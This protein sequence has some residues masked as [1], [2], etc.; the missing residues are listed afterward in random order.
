MDVMGILD[1]KEGRFGQT[2]KAMEHYSDPPRS[3]FCHLTQAARKFLLCGATQSGAPIASLAG[4]TTVPTVAV[5]G[6]P[7]NDPVFFVIEIHEEAVI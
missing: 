5:G 6:E 2:P 3:L 7:S 1:R 4:D